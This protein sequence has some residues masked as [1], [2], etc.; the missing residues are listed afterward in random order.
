MTGDTIEGSVIRPG[1][2]PPEPCPADISETRAEAITQ[3][4]T[5]K[6]SRETFQVVV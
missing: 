6:V 3:T 4:T 2:N 1:I 5:W